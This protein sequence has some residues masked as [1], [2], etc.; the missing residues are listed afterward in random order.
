MPKITERSIGLAFDMNGCPNYCRHCWLGPGS[1]EKLTESDVRWG[2]SEFKEYFRESDHPIEA[3]S[4]ATWFREPD[5]SDDYRQ[6]F[7][8]ETELSDTEPERYELLSIW[9]LANDP[10]YAEWAKSIGTEKCQ[11]SFFGME[12]TTDWF[13]RRKGAFRDA[14]TATERLFQVGIKPRWQVFLTTKLLPEIHDFA[15]LMKSHGVKKQTSEMDSDES[16]VFLHLPGPDF[17]A[18]KIRQYRPEISLVGNLPEV[19]LNSTR[20][21]FQTTTLWSTEEDLLAQIVSEEYKPGER[22]S[23]PDKLWLFICSNWDVYSNIG[24]LEK[25]WLLGN[26]KKDGARAILDTYEMNRNSGLQALFSVTENNLANRYGNPESN[27]IYT[28]AESLLSLYR[29]RYCEEEV[30]GG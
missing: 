11:I 24:T 5:Y 2:V 26:L 30:K 19:L 1:K 4:V 29:A 14:L 22:I 27:K 3:V 7:E 6:L 9:R 13:Y 25:W 16:E 21:H 10:K 12:D 23:L 18:R 15:D 17:E 20:K 28:N 8:L